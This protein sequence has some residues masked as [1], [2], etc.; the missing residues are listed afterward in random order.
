MA[1][2]Y[3]SDIAECPK[4]FR[5]IRIIDARIGPLPVRFVLFDA[6]DAIKAPLKFRLD[7]SGL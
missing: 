4:I 1:L 7:L 3:E 2:P 5:Q 6:R